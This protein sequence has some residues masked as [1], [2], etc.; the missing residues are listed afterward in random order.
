MTGKATHLIPEVGALIAFEQRIFAWGKA[1][2]GGGLPREGDGEDSISDQYM[3]A[4][5]WHRC[6]LF[7]LLPRII[8]DVSM[9]VERAPDFGQ[10]RKKLPRLVTLEA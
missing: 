8:K 4:L 2:G 6:V 9:Q 1:V 10:K 7:H 3:R 5:P